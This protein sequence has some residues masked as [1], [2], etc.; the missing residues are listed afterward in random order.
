MNEIEI[1]V[2]IGVHYMCLLFF[3]S[4]S[5]GLFQ[6]F[7]KI[8][9]TTYKGKDILD[10]LGPEWAGYMEELETEGS[11]EGEIRAPFQI[12]T[13]RYFATERFKPLMKEVE[14]EH[15]DLGTLFET[16]DDDD[17][18]DTSNEDYGERIYDDD[19][20]DDYYYDRGPK[21][22]KSDSDSGDKPKKPLA[23]AHVGGGAGGSHAHHEHHKKQQAILPGVFF[24][25]QIYPFAIEVTKEVV[26]FTHLLIRI[27]ATV[28][29]V[30][31]IFGWLDAVLYSRERKKGSGGYGR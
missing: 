10:S 19:D 12:E 8:V 30:F 24:V 4:G 7:I 9:P 5:T 21:Y 18:K 13:N 11:E 2:P 1:G 27:M 23:G 31:T 17:D 6:Y 16:K 22:K 14:D 3:R 15:W 28:G 29:G 25:Y 20:I 26:P